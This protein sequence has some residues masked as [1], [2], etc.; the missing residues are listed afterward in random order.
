MAF[1]PPIDVSES[2]G[3]ALVRALHTVAAADGAHPGEVALIAS[4][5][6]DL[7]DAPAPIA[8]AELA[9]ALPNADLRLLFMKLAYLVAHNE[10]GVSGPERTLLDAYASALGLT[11]ADRFALEEQVVGELIA[12]LPR[13]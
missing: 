10:G 13:E 2:E 1:F 7:G 5:F 12:R 9:A 3:R 11:D 6:S 4:L 8:P